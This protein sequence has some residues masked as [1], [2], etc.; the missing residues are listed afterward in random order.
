ML[1]QADFLSKRYGTTP[2]RIVGMD[3]GD[4]GFVLACAE[5]GAMLE[6]LQNETDKKGNPVHKGPDSAFNALVR[7]YER[8]EET[9]QTEEDAAD[10]RRRQFR[11]LLKHG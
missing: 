7:R 8:R 9:V 2:D 4:Y 5:A 3:F 11:S 10:L 6:S 1:T